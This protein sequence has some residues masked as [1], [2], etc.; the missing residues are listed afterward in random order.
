M[1]MTVATRVAP[2]RYGVTVL[3]RVLSVAPAAS[4]PRRHALT[5][6]SVAART[7]NDRALQCMPSLLAEAAPEARGPQPY[8]AHFANVPRKS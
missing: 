2:A 8:A 7:T 6:M 5:P 4:L 3:S 1:S